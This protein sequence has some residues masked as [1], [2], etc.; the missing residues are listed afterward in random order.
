M[1]RKLLILPWLLYS[2]LIFIISSHS[3]DRLPKFT[4]LGWDKVIHMMEFGVYAILSRIALDAFDE[5][6]ITIN[7][8]FLA[9]IM[10]ALYGFSDE[11][12]QSFVMGRTSSIYDWYADIIGAML[13]L[14]IYKLISKK[15]KLQHA[16]S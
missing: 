3:L 5:K 13:F 7:K 12:H 10:T 15:N 4:I 9:F 11:F 8:I 14:F 2:G 6:N 16:N 1:K